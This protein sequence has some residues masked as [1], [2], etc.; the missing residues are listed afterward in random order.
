MLVGFV[1]QNSAPEVGLGGLLV[2]TKRRS[3]LYRFPGVWDLSLSL[4]SSFLVLP[5]LSLLLF[6]VVDTQYVTTHTLIRVYIN[7]LA[8]YR[9]ISND[10]E[11]SKEQT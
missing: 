6:V 7:S 10:S 11:I 8:R 3:V 2:E 5:V 1:A 9:T 4:S